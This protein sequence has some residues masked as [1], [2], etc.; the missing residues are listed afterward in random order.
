MCRKVIKAKSIRTHPAQFAGRSHS[1]FHI[2]F[3]WQGLY[4]N[5]SVPYGIY[6]CRYAVI[7]HHMNGIF[8]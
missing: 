2:A 1:T 6:L 3:C 5:P 8:L 4:T 7:R